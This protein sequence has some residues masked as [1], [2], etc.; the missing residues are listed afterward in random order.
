M[1]QGKHRKRPQQAGRLPGETLAESIQRKKRTQEAFAQAT[2]D[3]VLEAKSEA[4]TQRALWLCCIAMNRAFG[5]G[6]K[7]FAQWAAALQECTDWYTEML[8]N[9]DDEYADEKL[10]REASRCSGI[11]VN[12]LYERELLASILATYE[13]EASATE[14]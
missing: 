13:E 4:R 11:Q 2:R 5:I 6:P 3:R 14:T 12:P 1:K 8:Q 10:R 7:R 9:V